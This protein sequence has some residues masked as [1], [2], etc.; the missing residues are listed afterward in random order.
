MLIILY[1]AQTNMFMWTT[2]TKLNG[3]D[4]YVC[5]HIHKHI[6]IYMHSQVHTCANIHTGV[7]TQIYA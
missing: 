6:H 7:Y 1:L 2:L 3:M 4:R 5:A